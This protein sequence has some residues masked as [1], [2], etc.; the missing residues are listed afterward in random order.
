MHGRDYRFEE[1]NNVISASLKLLTLHFLH[2]IIKKNDLQLP[3]EMQIDRVP[4]LEAKRVDEETN[5]VNDVSEHIKVLKQIREGYHEK[6]S[7]KVIRK[8]KCQKSQ[9]K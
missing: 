7:L 8:K 2:V 1:A 6:F 3:K 5:F 9:D 4:P